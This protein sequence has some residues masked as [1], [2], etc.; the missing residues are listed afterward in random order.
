M[1]MS[2]G[3]D[4]RVERPSTRKMQEYLISLASDSVGY[5]DYY[6]ERK[7]HIL[8]TMSHALEQREYWINCGRLQELQFANHLSVKLLKKEKLTKDEQLN[9]EDND[10]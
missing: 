2:G 9:S 10:K 8:S 3:Y 7:R 5:K 4:P 6:T 1:R